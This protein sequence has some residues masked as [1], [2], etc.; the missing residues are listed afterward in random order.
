MVQIKMVVGLGN[1]GKEYVNTRHNVGFEVI[2]SLAGQLKIDVRRKKFG[3][4]LGCGEFANTKLILL[5]PWQF[6][7]RS[8][9][10]TATQGPGGRHREARYRQY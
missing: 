2:D 6:M 1:P 9:Q 5:K 4:V 7:N 8:G 10:P 3:A